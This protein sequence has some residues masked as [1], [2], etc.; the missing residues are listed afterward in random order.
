MVAQ[1]TTDALSNI[2]REGLGRRGELGL[3]FV[4]PLQGCSRDARLSR[5]KLGGRSGLLVAT[6]FGPQVLTAGGAGARRR[7]HG[8]GCRRGGWRL[9]L[10]LRIWKPRWEGQKL[11]LCFKVL[12]L[13]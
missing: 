8:L 7:Y 10:W 2:L 13:G 1:P 6:M 12:S 11:Y 4:W 5:N 9:D 3:K